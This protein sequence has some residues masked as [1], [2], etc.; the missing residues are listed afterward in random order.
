MPERFIPPRWERLMGWAER[1]RSLA[2]REEHLRCALFEARK[3]GGQEYVPTT[4]AHFGHAFLEE[5]QLLR[6]QDAYEQAVEAQRRLQGLEGSGVP[7]L[8][9][10]VAEAA[11]QAGDL[12]GA[13]NAYREA[14]RIL[15]GMPPEPRHVAC[16]ANLA[17]L[18]KEAD[19]TEAEALYRRALEISERVHGST[20]VET[21]TT[22]HSLAL[23][24]ARQRRFPEALELLERVSDIFTTSEWHP[25][26]AI[27][28]REK[29]GVL[30]QAGRFEEAESAL[31]HSKE[32]FDS[33]HRKRNEGAH[34]LLNGVQAATWI[35]CEADLRRDQGR[36]A[37]AEALYQ[38]ALG[39]LGRLSGKDSPNLISALEGYARLL[40]QAGREQEAQ[41]HDL[42]AD[43]LK[44]KSTPQRCPG[45]AKTSVRTA[46]RCEHCMRPFTQVP[47][48]EPATP[49]MMARVGFPSAPDIQV[50]DT[51][52]DESPP[53]TGSRIGCVAYLL[54]GTL[55]AMLGGIG[56]LVW[57]AYSKLDS[58]SFKFLMAFLII[59]IGGGMIRVWSN[60]WDKEK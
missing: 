18:L 8:L 22:A 23:H 54:Y 17:H 51:G 41:V 59:S 25:A 27:T 50:Y 12:P 56:Y 7:G 6:A 46:E 30:S 33:A 24:L 19:P 5:R 2:Q 38:K 16:M 53:S 3:P 28:Q 9:S 44:E 47:P 26:A 32:L 20:H 36:I 11:E 34:E 39:D 49:E 45:C 55:F 31:R 37:E 42:E 13:R 4:L 1:S 48:I 10:Y 60:H 40:R 57:Y 14:L 58:K 15:E 29:A 43:R 35:E 21:A 52:E